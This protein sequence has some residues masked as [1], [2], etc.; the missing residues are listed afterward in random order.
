[1][2][3]GP[4][5]LENS[6]ALWFCKLGRLFGAGN[7]AQLGSGK[8]PVFVRWKLAR[9]FGEGKLRCPLGSGNL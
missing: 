6:V 7:F 1:M 3:R 2:F 5:K 9:L 8:S 4:V